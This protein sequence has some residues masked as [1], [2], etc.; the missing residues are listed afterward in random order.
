LLREK[1]GIDRFDLEIAGPGHF[2]IMAEQ[3]IIGRGQDP[4]QIDIYVK[5]AGSVSRIT[6]SD[7]TTI[8]L[9]LFQIVALTGTWI[10]APAIAIYQEGISVI[11][12]LLAAL[13]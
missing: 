2:R 13:P 9:I 1:F 7:S 12:E 11:P 3:K 8:Y 6:I 4:L 10:A 5:A